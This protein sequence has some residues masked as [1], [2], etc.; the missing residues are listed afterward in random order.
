MPI[1]NQPNHPSNWKLNCCVFMVGFTIKNMIKGYICLY[2]SRS[3][4]SLPVIITLPET[5][6]I[7]VENQWLQDEI[8]FWGPALLF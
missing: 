4:P 1:Q 8:S 5:K 3:Y 6:S 7:A 2:P